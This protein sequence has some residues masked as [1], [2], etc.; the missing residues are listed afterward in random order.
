MDYQAVRPFF[1]R[2]A[3][4][5]EPRKRKFSVNLI[6]SFSFD[7]LNLTVAL[8]NSTRVLKEPSGSHRSKGVPLMM[9]L[10][11]GLLFWLLAAAPADASS[12]PVGGGICV[13]NHGPI[14]AAI[15]HG[16]VTPKSSFTVG[17]RASRYAWLTRRLVR[18]AVV[19]HVHDD[20]VRKSREN[21]PATIEGDRVGVGGNETGPLATV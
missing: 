6:R 19:P 16:R 9:S 21:G 15:F 14:H 7:S 17:K 4:T 10:T 3:C 5:N 13:R 8:W 18:G 12:T 1:A 2:K 11:G 20:R